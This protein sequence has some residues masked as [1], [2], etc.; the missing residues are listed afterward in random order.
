MDK[1]IVFEKELEY[2]LNPKI[3]DFAKLAIATLPDYFFE[4]PASSTGKYHP[5][6]S[7]NEGGLVRHT[8]A[9]IRIAIEL[10]RISW[11]NFSGDDLDLS[12][13]ALLIHDGYK[14]G[15]VKETY[16]RADHPNVLKGELIKNPVLGKMI[17]EEQFNSILGMV[18]RHMG[19]WNTDFK[20][21]QEILDKPE[22]KLEKFVHLLIIW[23]VENV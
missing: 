1:V 19:Q 10:S 18:S 7:L 13:A 4:I 3:K 23:Q 9:A 14:S 11:W 2:I 12:I 20:T 8:R 16:T 21:K 17:P 6:Y 22:T 15:V 5:T